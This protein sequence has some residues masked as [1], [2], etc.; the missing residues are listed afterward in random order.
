MYY[1][2]HSTSDLKE[3]MQVDGQP[4]K[5]WYEQPSGGLPTRVV[6]V[7]PGRP[8]S[9]ALSARYGKDPS[10]FRKTM[11]SFLMTSDDGTNQLVGWSLFASNQGTKDACEARVEFVPKDGA[12][13]L[14]EYRYLSEGR[15]ALRCRRVE[16]NIHVPNPD[17]T[18]PCADASFSNAADA[19]RSVQRESTLLEVLEAKAFTGKEVPGGL[20]VLTS[21]V[22]EVRSGDLITEVGYRDP[23]GR[24][25]TMQDLRREGLQSRKVGPRREL[26]LRIRRGAGQA[27][28]VVD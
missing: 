11:T 18:T 1:Y 15:C 9:F 14:L 22:A 23:T 4:V 8:T 17:Q 7:E 19:A 28:V 10:R 13:Y 6:Q 27:V 3:S 25:R 16:G 5:E 21:S 26:V 12:Q 20:E 24:S 2:A